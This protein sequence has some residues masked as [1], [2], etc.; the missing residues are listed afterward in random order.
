MLEGGIL[1]FF[2]DSKHSAASALVRAPMAL[3]Q[4]SSDGMEPAGQGQ[5]PWDR[6]STHGTGSEP[7]G[8]D[9]DSEDVAKTCRMGAAPTGNMALASPLGWEFKALSSGCRGSWGRG[10][11]ACT[12]SIH[13]VGPASVGQDKD[14]QDGVEAAGWDQHP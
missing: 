8:L 12:H 4:G 2:K 3:G 9:K 13:R 6:A 7:M 5:H 14:P 10:T 11:M 1:T